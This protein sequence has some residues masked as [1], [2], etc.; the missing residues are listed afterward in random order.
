MAEKAEGF[1]F[2]LSKGLWILTFTKISNQ[3]TVRLGK[4]QDP[5]PVSVQHEIAP[6]ASLS[7]E[8]EVLHLIHQFAA[9]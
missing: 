7:W 5:S 2:E 3:Q 1:A 9:L 6:D 4:R 8:P